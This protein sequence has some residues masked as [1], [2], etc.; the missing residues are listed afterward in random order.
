MTQQANQDRI[1]GNDPKS[2][3]TQLTLYL[4]RLIECGRPEFSFIIVTTH[5][6][7]VFDTIMRSE[8]S[9]SLSHLTL[10]IESCCTRPSIRDVNILIATR[11][12][13]S[14]LT[15]EGDLCW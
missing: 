15:S 6:Q 3:R 4:P 10:E 1:N 8:A 11:S 2:L 9:Y 12:K 7:P 14:L 5:S 13:E